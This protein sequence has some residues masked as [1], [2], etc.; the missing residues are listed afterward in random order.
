VF[1]KGTTQGTTT[2]ADGRFSL[3]V[4]S[5]DILSASFIGYKTLE[6][7][8]GSQ[9]TI[10]LTMDPDIS[11]LDEVVVIGYTTASNKDVASSVTTV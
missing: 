10:D 5:G 6:I 11:E 1:V 2:D 8:V 9:T 4:Q 3:A 7:P